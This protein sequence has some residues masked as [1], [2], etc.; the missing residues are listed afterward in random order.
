MAPSALINEATAATVD[1]AACAQISEAGI[2]SRTLLGG[3][4]LRVV[5]FSFAEGQELTTHT[6]DRRALVQVL[7]GECDF[8]FNGQWQVLR[9]GELLHM[10]PG[11]VHAV[12]AGRGAFTML[13]TLGRRP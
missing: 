6:S 5:H 1:L 7:T 11:H 4:D 9:P 12:R 13:L 10:P 3:P 2:V 8:E